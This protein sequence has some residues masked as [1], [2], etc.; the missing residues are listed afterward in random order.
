MSF[1]SPNGVLMF[2]IKPHIIKSQ[3]AQNEFPSPNG[4]LMFSMPR[5]SRQR[6]I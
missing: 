3:E 5:S 1:P 4:V 2:S 6:G